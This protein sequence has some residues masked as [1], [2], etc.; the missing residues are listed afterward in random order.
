[1]DLYHDNVVK[2]FGTVGECYGIDHVA[3]RFAVSVQEFGIQIFDD[4]GDFYQNHIISLHSSCL[5]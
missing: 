1:M 2:C 4:E 3:N 5:P